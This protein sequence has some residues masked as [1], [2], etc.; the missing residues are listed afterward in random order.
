MLASY[1]FSIQGRS[2]K[3][4]E[5]PCQD[6]S[7]VVDISPAWKCIIVADGVGSCKNAEIA[8]KTA[9]ETVSDVIKK[10]FP[11]NGKDRDF[12]SLLL[13]AGHFAANAIET[14][15]QENDKGNQKEYHT[16]L[17]FALVSRQTAYYFSVG[18][19]GIIALDEDSGEWKAVTQQ[20]NDPTGG[21]YTIFY[22]DHYKVGK[23]N[24]KPAAVLAVTDGIYNECFPQILSDE[25]YKCKVPFLN[26]LTTYALGLSE[27]EEKE[28]TEKQ[29]ENIVKYLESEESSH[30]T[31]D[32]S[33]SAVICTDSCLEETDIPY[34]SPDWFA[35]F[36]KSLKT[37][38]YSEEVKI[39]E[40]EKFIREYKPEF[41]EDEVK[42][43][44]E[45]YA[46][47]KPE[48]QQEGV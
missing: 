13:T 37:K 44:S 21:V 20:D 9:V 41:S 22:R 33:V 14:Y 8:S 5:K 40:F 35:V 43:F 12:Q 6:N 29:K 18:D 24:F 34:E 39:K 42:K 1:N 31:D 46:E 10:G 26:F 38:P 16:T 15:V 47:N 3:K 48:E 7:A 17:A 27:E 4:S 11:E 2:H 19:S 32:L 25:K 45:K 36:W 23:L 30:I 28:A